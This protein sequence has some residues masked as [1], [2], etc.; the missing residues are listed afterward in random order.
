[1]R[2]SA[3]VQCPLPLPVCFC[4]EASSGCISTFSPP[5]LFIF[6]DGALGPWLLC[7]CFLTCFCRPPDSPW[8]SAPTPGVQGVEPLSRVPSPPFSSWLLHCGPPG[9]RGQKPGKHPSAAFR[10]GPRA[11]CLQPPPGLRCLG[12]PPSLSTHVSRN[13]PP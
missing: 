12:A 8:S 1:M 13:L 7:A 2:V 6:R 10:S 9:A 3:P 5:L 11:V 4:S